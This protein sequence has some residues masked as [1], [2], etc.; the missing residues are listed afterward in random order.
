MPVATVLT[1]RTGKVTGNGGLGVKTIAVGV[2][3]TTPGSNCTSA[4]KPVTFSAF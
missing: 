1:T 3:S 2:P 4:V